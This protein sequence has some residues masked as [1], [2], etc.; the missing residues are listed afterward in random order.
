[1]HQTVAK[2]WPTPRGGVER[3]LVVL[4]QR[5]GQC[6]TVRL[7]IECSVPHGV[8]FCIIMAAIV[9]MDVFGAERLKRAFVS[10]HLMLF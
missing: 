3:P 8:T 2:R 5:G 7:V 6:V 4:C 1:M 9:S 10:A